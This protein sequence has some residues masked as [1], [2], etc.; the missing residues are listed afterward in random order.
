MNKLQLIQAF[1]NLINVSSDKKQNDTIEDIASAI[2]EGKARIN[3]D[4][5]YSDETKTYKI[6]LNN[7]L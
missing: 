7:N 4:L 5:F 3:I 6:I 2:T 1:R